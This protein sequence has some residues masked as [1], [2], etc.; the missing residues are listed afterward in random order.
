MP[1]LACLSR[2][3]VYTYPPNFIQF[4]VFYGPWESKNPMLLFFN[5]VILCW[6]RPALQRQSWMRVHIYKH[7][8]MQRY[9][10]HFRI[11]THW[12]QSGIHKLCYLKRLMDQQK[13]FFKTSNF[14]APWWRAISEPHQ[15]WHGD[16]GRPNL[17]CIAKTCSPPTHSFAVTRCYNLNPH[18]SKIPGANLPKF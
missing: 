10:E 12:W 6:L 11:T 5:F 4:S 2:H 1:N 8:P 17:S 16:R 9:Q 15:T 3:M 13:T 7:S 14:F 18:N